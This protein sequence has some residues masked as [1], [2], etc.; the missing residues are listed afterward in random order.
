MDSQSA[1]L[2][3]KWNCIAEFTL[4]P[5]SGFCYY[6]N[7]SRTVEMKI[8]VKYRW[9]M[10]V[11]QEYDGYYQTTDLKV[12]SKPVEYKI[13]KKKTFFRSL[14]D[15]VSYGAQVGLAVLGAFNDHAEYIY[16]AF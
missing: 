7:V 2:A 1:R 10:L 3:D 4:N 13:E 8:D 15:G 14:K 6:E 5:L 12:F 16:P 11:A 9:L